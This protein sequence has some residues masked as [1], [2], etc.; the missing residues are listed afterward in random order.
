MYCG[1]KTLNWKA[2]YNCYRT[3][4][5]DIKAEFKRLKVTKIKHK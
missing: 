2:N 1:S 5:D 4:C 3:Q